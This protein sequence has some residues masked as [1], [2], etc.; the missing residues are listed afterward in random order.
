VPSI[1][2]PG[3][4]HYRSDVAKI[5]PLPQAVSEFVHDGDTVA[6]EG[7]THLIPFAAGHEIIR[8]HRRELTLVRMTPDLIYDQLIGAGCASR[9]VF[10]WGGNRGVGSL[11]RMRDAL[12]TGWPVPLEIEEHSHAGMANRYVAG[13]SGLP[14]AVLAAWPG[15]RSSLPNASARKSSAPRARIRSP[16]DS[17]GRLPGTCTCREPRWRVPVLLLSSRRHC[18]R[19]R[20]PL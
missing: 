4:A 1:A 20:N 14:F 11:H 6:L 16:P 10:S 15:L 2:R 13:A 3:W 7:F 17:P 12:A 5:V 8:Q 19:R 18:R 9:L